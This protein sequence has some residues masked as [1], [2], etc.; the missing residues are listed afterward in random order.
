MI[1]IATPAHY[2]SAKQMLE[3]HAGKHDRGSLDEQGASKKART[4]ILKISGDKAR[5]PPN[6]NMFVGCIKLAASSKEAFALY[7]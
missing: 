5:A 7:T 1:V 4:G 6:G 3:C 2:P